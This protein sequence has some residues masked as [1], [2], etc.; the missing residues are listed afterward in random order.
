MGIQLTYNFAKKTTLNFGPFWSVSTNSTSTATTTHEVVSNDYAWMAI[1]SFVLSLTI[2]L[3]LIAAIVYRCKRTRTI[4]SRSP[5]IT[6][7]NQ[8]SS[9]S[10]D[11]YVAMQDLPLVNPPALIPVGPSTS[12]PI[13]SRK[14]KSE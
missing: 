10:S 2:L 4:T 12:Q 3:C 11:V 5:P 8:N 1:V 9:S 14:A 6:S 7:A 13:D